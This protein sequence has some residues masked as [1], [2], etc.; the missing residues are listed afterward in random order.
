MTRDAHVRSRWFLIVIFAIAM[1]WVEAAVVYDLRVML[2]RLNP[3]QTNPLPID[4][5]VGHVELVREAATLVMLLT[6]GA[7]AGRT[8]RSRLAY[9]AIAFGVWDIFYYL[10]LKAMS[11][12]PRSLFDCVGHA[13]EPAPQPRQLT[14]RPDLVALQHG[15]RRAGALPVHGGCARRAA[16]RRPG[17]AVGVAARVQLAVVRRRTGIDGRADRRVLP[18]SE[19]TIHGSKI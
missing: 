15:R 8:G 9:S 17:D 2:D 10:F 13:R 7:L 19:S 18:G 6:V 3:Y 11:G 14:D 16:R 1:A 5:V 12:W 4:G